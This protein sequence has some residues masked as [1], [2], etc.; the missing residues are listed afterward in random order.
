MAAG[1]ENPG[2][3]AKVQRIL[4]GIL[5]N[6]TAKQRKSLQKLHNQFTA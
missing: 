5:Q 2:F 4:G 3:S 6:G 1:T